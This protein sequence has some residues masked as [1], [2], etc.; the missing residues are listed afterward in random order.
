MPKI[1]ENMQVLYV[2]VFEVCVV[3]QEGVIIILI[4]C[5]DTLHPAQSQG[6]RSLSYNYSLGLIC[7]FEHVEFLLNVLIFKYNYN[8]NLIWYMCWEHV[9]FLGKCFLKLY[10]CACIKV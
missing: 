1:D 2:H 8:V 10:A 4:L 6:C 7:L 9:L 5:P 3:G